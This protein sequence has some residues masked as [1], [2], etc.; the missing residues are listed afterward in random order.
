MS[1]DVPFFRPQV[2]GLVLLS[3]LALALALTFVLF[4]ALTLTLVL[5]LTLSLT[6]TLAL[7]SA[8]QIIVRH[9][10]RGTKLEL[11]HH[12]RNLPLVD[13]LPA[14]F[15]LNQSRVP[16]KFAVLALAL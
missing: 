5:T 3:Q 1:H 8:I 12:S 11:F 14:A 4:L 7:P 13:I 10:I 9:I 16:S 2:S 15:L 6:L